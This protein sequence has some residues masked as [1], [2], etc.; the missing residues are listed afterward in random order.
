[1]TII[2]ASIPVL[3]VIVR[4]VKSSARKYYVAGG[5]TY[6]EGFTKQSRLRS[7]NNTVVVTAQRSRMASHKQ[8]DWSDKSILDGNRPNPGKI[9]Q[10]NEVAVEYQDRKDAESM[11]YEMD[12]M[13]RV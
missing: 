2:A 13:R 6:P 5:E 7:Q 9:V 12:D 1:M 4:E 3:R 11:E 10:T 8:D